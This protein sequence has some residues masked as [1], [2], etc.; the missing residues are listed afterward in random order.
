MYMLYPYRNNDSLGEVADLA[1]L[2]ADILAQRVQLF[3]GVCV[4]M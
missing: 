1:L 3:F 4:C 2:L